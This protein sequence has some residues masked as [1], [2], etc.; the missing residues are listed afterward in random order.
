MSSEAVYD[1]EYFERVLNMGRERSPYHMDFISDGEIRELAVH[2]RRVM[3]WNDFEVS[4][5]WHNVVRDCNRLGI[6]IPDLMKLFDDRTF[7]VSLLRDEC[8]C[9]DAG[10]PYEQGL[11]Y[12]DYARGAAADLCYDE[13]TRI[14]LGRLSQGQ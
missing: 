1:G 3:G 2:A 12:F 13:I 14:E 7:V 5:V 4:N 8:F 6:K 10:I 11:R 9:W